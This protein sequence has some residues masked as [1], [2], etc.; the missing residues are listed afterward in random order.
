MRLLFILSILVSMVVAAVGCQTAK[1]GVDKNNDGMLNVYDSPWILTTTTDADDLLILEEKLTESADKIREALTYNVGDFRAKIVNSGEI[2]IYEHEHDAWASW[3][4][5]DG[6]Q[7]KVNAGDQE[8]NISFKDLEA[9]Y[10][11]AK[12]MLGEGNHE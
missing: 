5:S 7:V 1:G 2:N 12:G 4:G 10:L 11:W 8:I 9:I 6:F 3:G